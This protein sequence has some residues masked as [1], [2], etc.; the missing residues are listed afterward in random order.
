MDSD[1]FSARCYP[2]IVATL[3]LG[4]VSATA[5]GTPFQFQS[6]ADTTI[7]T[8]PNLG[9]GSSPQGGSWRMFTIARY[10]GWGDLQL[11]RSLVR[12]DLSSLDGQTILSNATLSFR[13]VDYY[14][15]KNYGSPTT[16]LVYLRPVTVG[17]SE[18]T[19]THNNFGG[20]PGVQSDEYGAVLASQTVS[21]SQLNTWISWTVPASVVQSWIDAPSSNF[22][23]ML[24][25][26]NYDDPELSWGCRESS[27]APTLTF[28]ATPEPGSVALL[29]LGGLMS[30]RRRRHRV[31]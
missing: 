24:D 22:G 17:W 16:Q 25:P 26:P 20:E 3:C 23:L 31:A 6:I 5:H 18:A 13:L 28:E 1:P 8:H 10:T 14:S 19:A 27:F 7:T 4:I 29:A 9:S 12:F 30:M 21:I 15:S 11:A 2:G